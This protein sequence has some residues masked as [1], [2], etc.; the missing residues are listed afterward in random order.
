M[1]KLGTPNIP[2]KTDESLANQYFERITHNPKVLSWNSTN[3]LKNQE[4]LKNITIFIFNIFPITT[5][6]L[7]TVFISLGKNDI[8][9]EIDFMQQKTKEKRSKWIYIN[10]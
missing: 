3:T 6:F 2:I 4:N 9:V 1:Q 10:I 7:Q 5:I 8:I